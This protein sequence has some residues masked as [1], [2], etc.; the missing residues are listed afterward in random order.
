VTA[1]GDTVQRVLSERRAEK[2]LADVVMGGT[3]P[4]LTL[5]SAKALDAI[6]DALIL[7]E[8]RDE[9]KWWGGKH[10]YTDPEKKHVLSYIGNPSSGDLAYNTTLVNGGEF[11][12]LWDFLNPKWKSKISIRDPRTVG[13]GSS[14]MRMFY[15][16][17]KL[18]PEFI[19]RLFSEMEV[20]L[21]RDPRQGIDWLVTGKY[22]INFFSAP[23]A[24]GR[25][26]G[27]GLPVAAFGHMK[28]GAYIV[29]HSGVIGIVNR[30]PHPNAAKIFVNWLLSREGQMTMQ[31]EYAKAGT[32]TSNSRRIDIPKDMVPP[33]VRLQE[34][35]EYMDVETLPTEPGLKVLN[36]ALARAGK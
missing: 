26:Q 13:P 29:S 18:G 24:L 3:T 32:G 20:T 19:L 33:S 1:S 35:V 8:V 7:P 28:E 23:S 36:E 17:P 5:H 11:H 14:T 15:F 34:G 9:S 31:R 2:Y 25:A 16:H 4:L 10:Y 12:S 22:P 21:F 6:G 27:Q 30:A